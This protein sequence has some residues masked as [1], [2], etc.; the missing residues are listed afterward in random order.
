MNDSNPPQNNQD[1]SPDRPSRPAFGEYAPNNWQPTNVPEEVSET[2]KTPTRLEGVPHNLGVGSGGAPTA[3]SPSQPSQHSQTSGSDQQIEKPAVPTAS[4]HSVEPAPGTTADVASSVGS[5]AKLSSR[6]RTDRIFT[7]V[8]LVIGAF[9]ALNLALAAMNMGRQLYQLAAAAGIDDVTLPGSINTLE[10]IGTITILS[11]Y[12]V[13]LLWSVHRMRRRKMTF[14]VPLVGGVLAFITLTV[15]LAVALA[16]VPEIM[17]NITPEN[18]DTIIN[19][20][21]NP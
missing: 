17:M 5:S 7:I 13:V 16:M 19:S 3:Q 12:A 15:F 20:L 14:W 6:I 1:N 11:I 4:S 10:S 2:V 8:L 18:F 21:S 9:G